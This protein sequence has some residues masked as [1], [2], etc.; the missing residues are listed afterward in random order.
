MRSHQRGLAGA[1]VAV[2]LVLAAVIALASLALTR[3]NRSA[4]RGAELA[5]KFT[6]IKAAL[7]QYV[8]VTGRLP[9]RP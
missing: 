5:P 7:V 8:A 4:E 3:A 2:V 6:A 1:L 9:S